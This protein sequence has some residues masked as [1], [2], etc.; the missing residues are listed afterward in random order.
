MRIPTF[1]GQAANREKRPIRS[2]TLSSP[3]R[4]ARHW[5][6]DDASGWAIPE[7]NIHTRRSWFW[8]P[9][10][11]KTLKTVSQMLAAYQTS[12]GHGANLLVN[13]TPDTRGLVPD[14]EMKMLDT[15]GQALQKERARTIASTTGPGNWEEGHTLRLQFDTEQTVNS[16]TIEEDLTSGQRIRAYR[17]ELLRD[18]KWHPVAE[19]K[20]IGR[21]RIQPF[22]PVTTAALRLKILESTAMPHIRM[23]SASAT[24]A[25]GERP[26]LEKSELK[27]LRKQAA[28][29]QRRIVYNDDGCH[30][31]PGN[32]AEDWLACRVR[33]FAEGQQL[34]VVP[35]RWSMA[36]AVAKRHIG[37]VLEQDG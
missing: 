13:L 30:G 22:K 35:R 10:S 14:A 24:K 3:A 32:T 17:I 9:D 16:V 15:F 33:I 23:L 12:I 19:G 4:A 31:T 7:A 37:F 25:E 26:K 27:K 2:G 29:R 5:L 6:P 11:D 34:G 21:K 20:S 36:I 18:G 1:A 8:S 28:N